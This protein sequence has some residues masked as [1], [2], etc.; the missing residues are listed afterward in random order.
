[1][2][3]TPAGAA[4]RIT[5]PMPEFDL[6]DGHRPGQSEPMAEHLIRLWLEADLAVVI[7][8]VKRS[9]RTIDV[10]EP[11]CHRV[12]PAQLIVRREHQRLLR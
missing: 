11:A 1:M 3:A 10:D 6:L 12:P 4:E 5:W 7:A 8:N 9:W 2:F